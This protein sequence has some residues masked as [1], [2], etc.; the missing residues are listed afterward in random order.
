MSFTD[1]TVRFEFDDSSKKEISETLVNVY[2][3]LD[4]KGYNPINQMVG[5]V[6]SGDPAYIPRHDDARN[7]IRRFDRDDIVEELIKEYLKAHGVQL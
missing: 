1:E 3:A 2:R 7:K 4:A 5:Y 6:L